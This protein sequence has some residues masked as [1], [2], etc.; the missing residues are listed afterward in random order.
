M[1]RVRSS[2]L[3]FPAASSSFP[4]AQPEYRM[5]KRP[6]S[7]V[8]LATLSYDLN[9]VLAIEITKKPGGAAILRC[10]RS[11]GSI[12]WQKR[13]AG[14]AG[15]F[16]LHDLT[17]FAVESEL[18]YGRGFFGLVASGWDIDDTTGKGSRGPLPDETV[19]VEFLVGFLDRERAAG[20]AT[21]ANDFNIFAALHAGGASFVS[22]SL[23][24]QELNRVR[25]RRDALFSEWRALPAGS[26]LKLRWGF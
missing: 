18:G 7:E 16:V 4:E 8:I 20:S 9:V 6:S 19:A 10:V 3:R 5:S 11:D 1:G 17:H 14:D 2:G 25:A 22:R 23:S 21:S 15:F 13:H 26:A 24:D 12:T